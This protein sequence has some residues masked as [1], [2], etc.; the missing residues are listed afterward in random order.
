MERF[1][2]PLAFWLAAAAVLVPAVFV[3]FTRDIV[4]ACFWLLGCLAGVAGLYLLLGADFVGFAQILIYVGGI[5]ILMIFGILLTTRNP[6]LIKDVPV[7]ALRIPAVLVGAAVFAVL[8]LVIF[9]APWFFRAEGI[10][11]AGRTS[12]PIGELLMTRYILPFE[13]VSVLLLVALVGAAY[14]ARRQ[15]NSTE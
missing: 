14:L 12:A 4:R 9:T 8:A 2:E 3:V 15:T 13:I 1:F 6:I 11:E 5:M 7:L 10:E